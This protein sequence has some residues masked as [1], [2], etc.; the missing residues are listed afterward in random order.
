MV[1][2]TAPEAVPF[3]ALCLGNDILAD[4]AL[5]IRVAEALRKAGD[6]RIDVVDTIEAGLSLLDHLSGALRVVV[7]DTILTG[8]VDP[9]TLFR[10]GEEDVSRIPGPS[11]HY[12]GLFEALE[13]GRALGL[14]MPEEV[15]ILAVEGSD[16]TTL[17]GAMDPRVREAGGRVV[18][19][20]REMVGAPQ[21]IAG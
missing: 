17:G 13:R 20:V 12:M 10:V 18:A 14:P 6:P 4:D 16:C 5:G 19:L 9:G 3:R 21:G 1:A 15:T 2:S 7:V 8:T 11:P